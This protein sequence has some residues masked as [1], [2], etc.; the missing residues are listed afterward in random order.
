MSKFVQHW[1]FSCKSRKHY[2]IQN[3]VFLQYL[4]ETKIICNSHKKLLNDT[5]TKICYYFSFSKCKRTHNL[6]KLL[7]KNHIT[8]SYIALLAKGQPHRNLRRQQTKF[9]LLT[10][11]ILTCISNLQLGYDCDCSGAHLV[12]FQII[13]V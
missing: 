4:Y 5:H 8:F 12:T 13:T 7:L 9:H 1:P 11:S 6:I 10:A 2:M 3:I